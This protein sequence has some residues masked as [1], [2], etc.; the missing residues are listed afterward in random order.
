MTQLDQSSNQQEPATGQQTQPKASHGQT[1]NQLQQN[2]AAPDHNGQ[3]AAGQEPIRQSTSQQGPTTTNQRS[4][5]PLGQQGQQMRQH[6][7][8]PIS[9]QQ[10]QP[11]MSQQIP[12]IDPEET[13]LKQSIRTRGTIRKSEGQSSRNSQQQGRPTQNQNENATISRFHQT[14]EQQ[15]SEEDLE[16][17]QEETILKQIS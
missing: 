2:T 15:P 3:L 9:N 12:T 13:C 5:T 6:Q 14:Q 10:G 4:K 8:H 16:I 11:T 17:N 7:R 1:T